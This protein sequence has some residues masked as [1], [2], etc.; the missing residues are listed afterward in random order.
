MQRFA[1]D[2]IAGVAEFSDS[3]GRGGRGMFR[4]MNIMGTTYDNTQIQ[5]SYLVVGDVTRSMNIMGAT[6]AKL[7]I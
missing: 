1:Y 6:N 7:K 3:M 2:Y 4:S 5:N